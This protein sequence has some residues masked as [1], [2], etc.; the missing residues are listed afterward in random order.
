[1]ATDRGTDLPSEDAMRRGV[2][3]F[4]PAALRAARQRA[5]WDRDALADASGVGASTI[6]GWERG[7]NEPTAARLHL[8]ADA[9]GIGVAD[10]LRPSTRPTLAA[11]RTG[12]GLPLEAAAR[13]AGISA[14]TLSRAENGRGDIS[15]RT[16]TSLSRAYGL[17]ESEIEEAWRLGRTD[18]LKPIGAYPGN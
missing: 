8:V 12:Q 5:G 11:L 2:R 4:S 17:D 7:T 6:G 16:L 3:G 9:L 15:P 1:M 13:A 10:L 18:R 14:A